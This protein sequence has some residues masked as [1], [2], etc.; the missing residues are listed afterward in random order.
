MDTDF[1]KFKE[2]AK[3]REKEGKDSFF[4]HFSAGPTTDKVFESAKEVWWNLF[5]PYA[6]QYLPQIRQ[7]EA[8]DLGCGGGAHMQYSSKLFKWVHGV[9]VHD[10]FGYPR[11]ELEARGAGNISFSTSNGVDL[12]FETN[13]IDFVYS[14]TVFMHFPNIEVVIRN[15]AEISRIIKIGGVGVIYFARLFR[16]QGPE[17]LEE[18]KQN[19]EKEKTIHPCGHVEGRGKS[20]FAINMKMAMWKME[21]LLTYLGLTTLEKTT[22]GSFKNGVRMSGNQHG[23]VFMKRKH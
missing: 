6:M 16:P 23:I 18:W 9:D 3:I 2:A 12:P 8:L 1:S 15:L 14:W 13:S 19:L 21:E 5:H 22:T 10:C 4:S 20:V 17:T 11:T 7:K